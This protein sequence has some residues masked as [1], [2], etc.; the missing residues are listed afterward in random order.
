MHNTKYNTTN[1]KV[2]INLRQGEKMRPFTFWKKNKVTLTVGLAAIS[3]MT[4]L[5]VVASDHDDGESDSKSRNVSLTDLYAFREDKEVTGGSNQH[6]VFLINTNPRS[7]PQQ[8]YYFST[9]AYYDLHVSRAGISKDVAA[10]TND[11]II[12]RFQFGAPNGSN[13]QAIT[14]SA[15]VDGVSTIIS[16]KDGGGSILTTPFSGA[17][18][19]VNSD[20]TIG[21]HTLKVFAGLR[22]DP[23]FFDVTA[24]FRFRAAAASTNGTL[25]VSGFAAFPTY[26]PNGATASDFTQSYNV[27]TIAVRVPIAFLQK[28]ADTVFDTWTTISLA[29]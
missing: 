20:I 9:Q 26:T 2:H 12:L 4:T 22:R 3:L 8:Q 16:T 15:I 5:A 27:N 11:N 29:Q 6:L 18:A 1:T 10:T 19:P 21:A 17:A 24:F 28:N 7:L 13:Q 25:P 23:F 14:V